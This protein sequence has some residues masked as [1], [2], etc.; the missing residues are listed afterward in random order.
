[1]NCRAMSS[2]HNLR[3]GVLRL[4]EYIKVIDLDDSQLNEIKQKKYNELKKKSILV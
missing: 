4:S 1:L 2:Y 3:M